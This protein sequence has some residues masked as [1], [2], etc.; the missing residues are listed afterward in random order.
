MIKG[1]YVYKNELLFHATQKIADLKLSKVFPP[2]RNLSMGF[3]EGLTIF[4]D[5]DHFVVFRRKQ[6][7][8]ANVIE[9]RGHRVF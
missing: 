6:L 9:S 1:N 7:L 2:Q 3:Q 5:D 4:T 8:T